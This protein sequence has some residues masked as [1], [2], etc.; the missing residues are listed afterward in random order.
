MMFLLLIEFAMLVEYVDYE[1]LVIISQGESG[2]D[3]EPGTPGPPGAK[4]INLWF[5]P[6]SVNETTKSKW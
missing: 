5:L 6:K 4:V 1:M 2:A 3:G